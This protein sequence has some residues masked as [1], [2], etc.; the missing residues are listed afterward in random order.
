MLTT[1][2]QEAVHVLSCLCDNACK[3][4]LA[5]WRKSMALCPSIYPYIACMWWTGSLVWFK[6]T[7]N[8]TRWMDEAISQPFPL[9]QAQL[10]DVYNVFR[11]GHTMYTIMNTRL[12]QAGLPVIRMY[13][14]LC[15]N[16]FGRLGNSSG[17]H[18]SKIIMIIGGVNNRYCSAVI[19]WFP[20]LLSSSK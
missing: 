10:S 18:R 17:I 14:N 3:R 4:S 16:D 2:S 19:P 9:S 13:R 5:I 8:L 1:G 20:W 12:I 15:N 11:N 6:Q 7:K